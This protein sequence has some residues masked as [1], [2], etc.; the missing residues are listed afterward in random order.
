MPDNNKLK[1]YT[2]IELNVLRGGSGG[3]TPMYGFR[4]KDKDEAAK[5][6]FNMHPG[7][8]VDTAI[9]VIPDTAKTVYHK[10]KLG[11]YRPNTARNK[12]GA[13]FINVG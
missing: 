9:L 8:P 11:V 10:T 5:N 1:N 2:V 3:A 7:I 4:A 6:F 12:L 13:L